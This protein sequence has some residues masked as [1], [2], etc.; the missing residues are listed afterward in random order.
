MIGVQ[1]CPPDT[2]VDDAPRVPSK[3]ISISTKLWSLCTPTLRAQAQEPG[4]AV[5]LDTIRF[6]TDKSDEV[7]KELR[8]T[9]RD[10]CLVRN[11]EGPDTLTTFVRVL[12]IAIETSFRIKPGVLYE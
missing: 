10:L 7:V 12:C 9:L 8:Q 11:Q 6:T 1:K 2:D 3:R 4:L 5:L